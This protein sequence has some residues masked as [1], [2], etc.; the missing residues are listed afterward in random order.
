VFSSWQQRAMMYDLSLVSAA[1][2]IDVDLGPAR[3]FVTHT[4]VL[5]LHALYLFLESFHITILGSELLLERADFSWAAS[6]L[7]RL[8]SLNSWVAL[9]CLELL[10][11]AENVENHNVSSVEDE[12]QEESETAEVHVALR[13]ELASLHLHTLRP[14]SLTHQLCLIDSGD[15]SYIPATRFR[16]GEG[17]ELYLDTIDTVDAIDEKDEDEDERD[18]RYVR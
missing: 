16:L 13:V 5:L 7:D 3:N 8:A 6:A 2:S 10:F 1:A 4:V 14:S 12:G 17:R 9:E 11:E 18:L 15:C